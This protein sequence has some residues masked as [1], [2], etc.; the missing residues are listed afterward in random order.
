[1]NNRVISLTC[2]IF[3]LVL[4]FTSTIL[5]QS[6]YPLAIGNR[7]DYH[8]TVTTYPSG[9]VVDRDVSAKIVGDTIASNG[10]HYFVFEG[11]DM[12]GGRYLRADSDWIYY[13][14]PEG[15]EVPFF[16]LHAVPHEVWYPDFLGWHSAMFQVSS[17]IEEFGRLTD[18][19]EFG[20]EGDFSSTY[21]NLTQLFGPLVFYENNDPIGQGV[22]ITTRN[23]VGAIIGD[24]VY[25]TLVDVLSIVLPGSVFLLKQNFPNPFNATTTIEV[26]APHRSQITV[27][28]F[29]VLGRKVTT[30]YSGEIQQG[31]YHLH[32]DATGFASGCYFLRLVTPEWHDTK[33]MV[34]QN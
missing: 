25:G 16:K 1:M 22:F 18:H 20:M 3:L 7:W 10:R 29:D 19:I 28:V 34:K 2:S 26:I 13:Y 33:V 12:I 23:L 30:L 4:A 31:P 8:E 11:V 14:D 17:I 6:F 27:S 21:V 9:N 24:T 15:R 5:A 32:W